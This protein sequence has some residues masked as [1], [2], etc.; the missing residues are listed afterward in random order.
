MWVCLWGV[1]G[2]SLRFQNC[3]PNPS[4]PSILPQLIRDQGR[5]PQ[6]LAKVWLRLSLSLSFYFYVSP[7]PVLILTIL[8]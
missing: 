4:L 6:G 5:E 3:G 8:L 2:A 7:S 1:A